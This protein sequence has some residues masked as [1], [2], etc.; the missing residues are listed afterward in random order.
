MTD[1]PDYMKYLSFLQV[2]NFPS[3]HWAIMSG[4][5]WKKYLAQ[6]ENGHM[7]EK[8]TNAWFFFIVFG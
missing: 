6:V 2:S 3:S 4:W 8:I 7:K 1:C 5:E